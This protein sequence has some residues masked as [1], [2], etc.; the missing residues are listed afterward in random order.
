M[1]VHSG[2][3]C[4]IDGHSLLV[5]NTAGAQFAREASHHWIRTVT[6]TQRVSFATKSDFKLTLTGTLSSSRK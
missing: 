4:A 6:H 5:Q 1:T 3:D 2:D